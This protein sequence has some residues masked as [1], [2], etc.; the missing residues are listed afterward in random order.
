M[1]NFLNSLD[2]INVTVSSGT[3]MSAPRFHALALDWYV[4][5]VG[6]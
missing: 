2:Q 6:N 5:I 1:F 4:A 3:E